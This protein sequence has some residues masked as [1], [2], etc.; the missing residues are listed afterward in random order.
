MYFPGRR[1]RLF[2]F[3]Y[4]CEG[5]PIGFIWWALPAYWAH[6]ELPVDHATAIT[7]YV[8]LP[9]S[10]KWLWAPVVDATAPRIGYLRWIIAMQL[11]MGLA[12][13]PVAWLDPAQQ[14]YLLAAALVVHA[15]AAATQDVGIDGLCMTMVEEHELGEVNG[16]MQAGMLLGRA[17]FGGGALL[18][19]SYTSLAVSIGVLVAMLWSSAVLLATFAPASARAAVRSTSDAQPRPRL[20]SVLRSPLLWLAIAFAL[21]SGASFE[22]VGALLG[23]FLKSAGYSLE[24]TAWFQLGPIAAAMA[25]GALFGG[26]IAD[27][28]GHV[29]VAA[30]SL[31]ALVLVNLALA[32]FETTSINSSE[33]RLTFIAVMYAVVGVF[34]ASS[35]ALFMDVARGPWQATVFSGLMGLTNACESASART[36]GM[37]AA[38]LGYPAAFTMMTL[39]SLVGLA[40]LPLIRRRN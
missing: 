29:R 37:L 10:L 14:F 23:P 22:S 2:A 24:Q 11:A 31:L 33:L 12:L 34:T 17:L 7:A 8:V 32:G 9:W 30:A 40:I 26:R 35:Y 6:T 16:W 19:A 18:L 13:V 38:T 27:R 1:E 21:V 15:F 25:C 36:A 20:I 28:F 39:P 4:F 3:L 5:A